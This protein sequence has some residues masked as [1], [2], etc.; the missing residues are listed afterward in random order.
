MLVAAALQYLQQPCSILRPVHPCASLEVGVSLC[1]CCWSHVQTPETLPE[2]QET[3][4]KW[5]HAAQCAQQDGDPSLLYL[6]STTFGSGITQYTPPTK[7]G[8]AQS[9]QVINEHSEVPSSSAS[10]TR[11][12]RGPSCTTP[13]HC[14]HCPIGV[15]SSTNPSVCPS[16]CPTTPPRSA[17]H[18]AAPIPA[19]LPQHWGCCARGRGHPRGWSQPPQKAE[20]EAWGGRAGRG[21][22]G[23]VGEGWDGKIGTEGMGR[24]DW[25]GK[26]GTEGMGWECK[27]R[28]GMEGMGRLGRKGWIGAEGRRK[29]R[30][31]RPGG[32]STRY[33]R[34]LGAYLRQVP[35]LQVEADDE[36]VPAD[37]QHQPHR[38]LPA[39]SGAV[40]ARCCVAPRAP[41]APSRCPAPPP[42]ERHPP[43]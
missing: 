10:L 29:V 17:L 12:P 37:P 34:R 19:R 18:P 13:P 11:C 4:E 16:I 32:S 41:P 9:G 2:P 28:D 25:D 8:T 42:V 26:D 31:G 21:G 36:G 38:V 15:P 43:G 27:R 24:E 35:D 5:Q 33:H 1:P 40:R 30:R 22:M 14:S 6:L 39:Q 20:P 23:W 3:L 7:P